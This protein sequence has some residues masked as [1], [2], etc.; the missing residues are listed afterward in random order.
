MKN[1]NKVSLTCYASHESSSTPCAKKSCRMWINAEKYQNCT[2]ISARTGPKTLREIGDI[3]GVTRMRICQI[4]K[5]VL[6]KIQ[7]TL[8]E[9][10]VM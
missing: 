5:I 4:E 6:N 2:V 9:S 7:Q 8:E 10:D 3:F 1:N